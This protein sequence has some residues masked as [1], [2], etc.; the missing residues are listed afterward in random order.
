MQQQAE[1]ETDTCHTINRWT[2]KHHNIDFNKFHNSFQRNK[3]LHE[4]SWWM[5]QLITSRRCWVTRCKIS[6]WSLRGSTKSKME[7]SSHSWRDSPHPA[8]EWRLAPRLGPGFTSPK[9]W[10]RWEGAC[11]MELNH[12]SSSSSLNNITIIAMMRLLREVIIFQTATMAEV[13]WQLRTVMAQVDAPGSQTLYDIEPRGVLT[14]TLLS[15]APSSDRYLFRSMPS[16]KNSL[17]IANTPGTRPW[18]KDRLTKMCSPW[19]CQS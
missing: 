12:R 7:S 16:S 8:M 13:S 14:W 19:Y 1:E 10:S 11:Q 2:H 18:W 5:C 17:E 6:S 15:G 4:E 9:R 3:T